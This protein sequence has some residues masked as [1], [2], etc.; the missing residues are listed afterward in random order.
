MTKH[1]NKKFHEEFPNLN[2]SNCSQTNFT[3]FD[4]IATKMLK[5]YKW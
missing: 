2:E 4:Q 5:W 3:F 1:L